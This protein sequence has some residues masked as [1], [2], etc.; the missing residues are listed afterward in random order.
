MACMALRTTSA[1]GLS[2]TALATPVLL[3]LLLLVVLVVVVVVLL[4][5]LLLLLAPW[6]L[7]QMKLAACCSRS[8]CS[9]LMLEE[10]QEVISGRGGHWG[11][12]SMSAVG[13]NVLWWCSGTQCKQVSKARRFRFTTVM[14]VRQCWLGSD[15]L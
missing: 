15:I 1:A 5:L 6:L 2:A 12:Q 11:M 14:L 10:L 7:L 3:L 4:L 13:G 9:A 8:S